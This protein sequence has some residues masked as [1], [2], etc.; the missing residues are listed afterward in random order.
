MS[1]VTCLPLASADD[2]VMQLQTDMFMFTCRSNEEYLTK[3]SSMID[4]TVWNSL[5]YTVDLLSELFDIAYTQPVDASDYL[6][7]YGAV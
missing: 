3:A 1:L 2:K 5:S 6:V 7:S 4:S